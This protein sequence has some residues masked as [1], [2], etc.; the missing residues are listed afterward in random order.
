MSIA[1]R[2]VQLAKPLVERFPRVAMAYRHA[3]DN[4][5]ALDAPRETPMGFRFTGNPL[6][7]NG[8]FEPEETEIVR[9]VLDS[10]DIV[11][12]VG[13]NIG[14]YCCL[15][16]QHGKHVVAFEPM[17]GNLRCLYQNVSANRWGDRIEI[18]PIALSDRIGTI[19][20]FGG[21]TGA[22]LI[23]GWAGTPEQYVETV[24]TSTLDT[25]LGSRLPGSRC[26]V[27][28]DIEG[29]ERLMLEGASSLLAQHPKP[30]WMVEISVTEHQPKDTVINPHL[31]STFQ[32][33]WERGYEAW[34]ADR[35]LRLVALAEVERIARTGVNTLGT[36]NFLFIEK[37]RMP[38]VLDSS[39]PC[40]GT[41]QA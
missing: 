41:S 2:L 11:V 21:G 39:R 13:A 15:A 18:F 30:V 3:R 14:Y 9:R 7:E 34:T 29:A 10:V 28:V 23:R 24:P 27:L 32:V 37:G 40:E 17:S 31:L 4:R 8:A 12:N 1:Q 36:H 26:F 33:F 22:S 20:I 16:L 6:M 38:A 5:R 19:Q 25:V 35:R